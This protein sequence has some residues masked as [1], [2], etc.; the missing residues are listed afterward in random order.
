MINFLEQHTKDAR[1][2][3]VKLW[4]SEIPHIGMEHTSLEGHLTH[5]SRD[6]EKAGITWKI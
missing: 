4:A 3:G 5:F 2:G 6:G 1:T